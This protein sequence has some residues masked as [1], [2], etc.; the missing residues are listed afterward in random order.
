[1]D[2]TP[3]S[4]GRNVLRWVVGAALVFVVV[5]A[6]ALQVARQ[7]ADDAWNEALAHLQDSGWEV[8]ELMSL[9]SDGTKTRYTEQVS[10]NYL[11]ALRR[12]E[13]SKGYCDIALSQPRTLFSSHLEAHV[14]DAEEPGLVDAA[15]EDFAAE[16]IELSVELS[17]E[18]GVEQTRL[19]WPVGAGGWR[20]P[21][22]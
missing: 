6:M 4:R 7:R 13:L 18:L 20:I 8:V 12:C 15:R 9:F 10:G 11:R 22:R 16:G 2:P 14:I 5:A 21:R 19:A 1:M 17:V 3:S